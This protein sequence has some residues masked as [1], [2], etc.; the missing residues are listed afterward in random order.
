MAGSKDAWPLLSLSRQLSSLSEGR[1][2]SLHRT[3]WNVDKNIS[4]DKALYVSC[5][6]VICFQCMFLLK[7]LYIS[8]NPWILAE[9]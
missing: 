1:P 5:V 3:E 4:G 2:P 8:T 9:P 7:I 6:S